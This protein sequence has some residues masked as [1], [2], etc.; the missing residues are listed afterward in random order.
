[1]EKRGMSGGDRTVDMIPFMAL[2][3]LHGY[4]NNTNRVTHTQAHDVESLIYA[5]VWVCVLYQAPGEI[6]T[7][8]T[9]YETNLK[10]WVSIET[11][12]DV[13]DLCDIKL[14]QLQSKSVLGDFT[15][16]FQPLRPFVE[17]IYDLFRSSINPTSDCEPLRHAD[18]EH[19][20][21]AF[22]T[23]EEVRCGAKNAKQILEACSACR[24][25]LL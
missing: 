2:A 22:L 1:M 12:Q 14:G 3:H 10:S 19:I 7:D 6:R 15:P 11:P 25:D 18:I 13:V 23:V 5:L 17:A 24:T 9:I 4:F 8:R 21:E 16:Y 20:L